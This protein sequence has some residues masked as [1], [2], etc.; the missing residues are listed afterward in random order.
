MLNRALPLAIATLTLAACPAITPCPDGPPLAQLAACVI[1]A[2]GWTENPQ[3][4]PEPL[5]ISVSGTID[6]MGVGAV[7]GDC[8][9][10]SG[11][12][13]GAYT[14]DETNAVWARVTD[15]VS[16]EEWIV[17]FVAPGHAGLELMPADFLSF[18]YDYMFGGFSPDRGQ[19]TMRDEAGDLVAWIGAAGSAERLEQPSEISVAKGPARCSE[20]DSCGSWSQ[21]HLDV[22]MPG[23]AESEIVDYGTTLGEDVGSDFT[24]H[25]GG[26]AQDTQTSTNCS[27]WFVGDLDAALISNRGLVWI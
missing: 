10:S 19:L 7:P 9:A 22:Q 5:G 4:Q 27:D 6:D 14:P 16:N 2:A 24:F 3:N 18:E 11:A 1:P 15:D 26:Y 12:H 23:A 17:A 8:F 21:Y 13:V 20:S 25:H